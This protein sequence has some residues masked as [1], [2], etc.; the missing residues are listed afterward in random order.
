MKKKEGSKSPTRK[1]LIKKIIQYEENLKELHKYDSKKSR[2]QSTEANPRQSTSRSPQHTTVESKYIDEVY[3]DEDHRKVKLVKLKELMVSELS[4]AESDKAL[5]FKKEDIDKAY[6][7]YPQFMHRYD[8]QRGSFDR[9]SINNKESHIKRPLIEELK[10][11]SRRRR[12]N[13]L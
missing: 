12:Q 7:G 2:Q 8:S 11:S 10:R 13:L 1:M 9:S 4:K 6:A 3:V 5:H